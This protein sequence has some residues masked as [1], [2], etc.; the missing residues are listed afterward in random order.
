MPG[1]TPGNA[2]AEQ[3]R[4][5][6]YIAKRYGHNKLRVSH[7]LNLILLH[8]HKSD[9][10]DVHKA[11]RNAGLATANIGLISDII[12]CPRM[13]YCASATARSIPIAQEAFFRDLEIE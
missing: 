5:M 2:S 7:E 8:V 11:V 12:A 4:V 6:A 10:P 9:L 1:K 13:D 3:M